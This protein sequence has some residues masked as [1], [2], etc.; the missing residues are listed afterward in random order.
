MTTSMHTPP[1]PVSHENE[2]GA[3][4]LQR[5]RLTVLWLGAL[6]FHLLH[7]QKLHPL[8]FVL[9]GGFA[10]LAVHHHQV[11]HKR[12]ALQ[13]ALKGMCLVSTSIQT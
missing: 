2:S 7:G 11:V 6:Q 10:S 12:H 8:W 13:H 9:Q 5:E 3:K 1:L 4:R